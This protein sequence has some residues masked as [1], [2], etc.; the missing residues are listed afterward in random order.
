MIRNQKGF[1]LVELMI[2]VAIIGILAAVAIPQYQ[3]YIYSAKA[4]ACEDN[5][6]SAKRLVITELAKQR[7]QDVTNTVDDDLNQ[8]GKEDPVAG[9]N[10]A[11]AEAQV[12]GVVVTNGDYT[13][14]V[15]NIDTTDLRSIASGDTVTIYG[16]KDEVVESIGF[17]KE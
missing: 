9:T 12:Q 1:T 13:A 16:A 6:D 14:C 2:V 4:T 15:I 3:K 10:D 17:T 8:G 5:Y 7:S 11:F